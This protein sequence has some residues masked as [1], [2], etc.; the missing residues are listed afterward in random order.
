LRKLPYIILL[1]ITSLL[2]VA[3]D[4]SDRW[5][6]QPN[7]LLVFSTD[8]IKFDTIITGQSSSTKTLIA[9]NDGKDG[10]RNIAVKLKEGSSSHFRVNVDG[11]YLYEGTG[12]DF[13]VRGNDSIVIRAEVKLPDM[14]DAEIRHYEDRLIFT[15]ESGVKEEIVLTAE[16]MNVKILRGKV[17]EEDETLEAGMPYLIYDS[18]VVKPNV[19]LTLN[20]GTKLLFHDEVSLDVHGTLFA[21]GT[22]EEPIIFRGDRMDRMFDYLPYDNTPNRWGGIHLYADSH[23]N[24]LEQCDIHSGNYGI[25]CDS[26][27]TTDIESNFLTLHHSIVH[28]IAGPGLVLHNT[29]ASI[30]GSQISNCLGRCVEILGG[31]VVMV[32]CT[33]A[34]F[35]AYVTYGEEAL[36]LSNMYDEEH[37]VHIDQ[38]VFLNCVITGYADDVI[39]GSILEEKDYTCNYI[40]ANC[41]LRTPKSEDTE[42]FVN[43]IYDNQDLEP[44][45]GYDHFVMVDKRNFLYDFAPWSKSAICTAGNPE[46]SMM[47]CPDDLRGKEFTAVDGKTECGAYTHV[48]EPEEE[49]K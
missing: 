49:N 44:L 33:I 9:F 32:H 36:Y 1:V 5:T 46:Y 29:V 11:Q 42:R 45:N 10:L 26:L 2:I 17:F 43:I 14:G 28:N 21:V 4:D 24:Y 22:L 30:T 16:G 6:T 48:V 40:F 15:L 20:P 25:Q 41:L 27:A 23:D 8:S 37:Y 31:D 3:C 13:E 39:M 38:A 34:Q 18:L 35:Y 7:A 19:T 12:N 47:F